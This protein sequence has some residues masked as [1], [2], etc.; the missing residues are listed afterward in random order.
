M[1]TR[2]NH[3]KIEKGIPIPDKDPITY[4]QVRGRG[5]IGGKKQMLQNIPIGESVT[6]QLS[7]I[8]IAKDRHRYTAI[9]SKH[10]KK[11]NWKFTFKKNNECLIIK[12]LK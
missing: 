7:D 4:V 12:R 2:A 8:D 11:L 1:E 5:F 10:K 9:I 3:Y 6:I